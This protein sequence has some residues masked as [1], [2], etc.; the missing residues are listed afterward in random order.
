[1][2]TLRVVMFR[3]QALLCL[4]ERNETWVA[5][6]PVV[7]GM[8]L[9]W[10]RQYRKLTADLRGLQGHADPDEAGAINRF[11]VAFKAT[12]MPGD[13]QAR[14]HV[15]IPLE[16]LFGWLMTI[17]PSRVAPESRAT[18]IAYQQE[19]DRVLARHF[20]RELTWEAAWYRQQADALRAG[21]YARYP[22]WRDLANAVL[23][24]E[25]RARTARRVHRHPATV[26]RNLNRMR[27][28]GL[29]DPLDTP[30]R[31]A[32]GTPVRTAP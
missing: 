27:A 24:G 9:S 23:L 13:D 3:G 7:E 10:P 16:R 17:Q 31:R 2:S 32:A 1:M 20:A 22:L 15:F 5:M 6:R 19:C 25:T 30:R 8:G 18:V 26:T 11:C 28:V 4:T 29:L 12:Q 14:E 21:W